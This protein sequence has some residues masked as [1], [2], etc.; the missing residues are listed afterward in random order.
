MFEVRTAYPAPCPVVS[1]PIWPGA[2]S[3]VYAVRRPEPG[4][5]RFGVAAAGRP[6]EPRIRVSS[7]G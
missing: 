7:G 5:T 2:A 6:T 1:P 4:V 3:R